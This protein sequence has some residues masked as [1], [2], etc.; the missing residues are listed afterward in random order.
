MMY[1]LSDA[2]P[3]FF[4]EDVFG[5]ISAAGGIFNTLLHATHL[6]FG[7]V[8]AND[9]SPNAACGIMAVDAHKCS[10]IVQPQTATT[11]TAGNAAHGMQL[12]PISICLSRLTVEIHF[13]EFL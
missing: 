8:A 3:Y 5:E 10:R 13:L 9:F 6:I 11:V 4:S 1:V 12:M 7:V 2:A